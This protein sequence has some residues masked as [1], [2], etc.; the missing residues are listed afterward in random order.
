ME[1]RD[2]GPFDAPQLQPPYDDSFRFLRA[3]VRGEITL[4]PYDLSSLE[5]NLIT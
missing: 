4:S 3:V 1:G 2:S 5:N